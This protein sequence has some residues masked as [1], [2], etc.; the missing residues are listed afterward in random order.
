MRLLTLCLVFMF[1]VTGSV[2]SQL[3]TTLLSVLPG[4][5]DLS[6]W[7]ETQR[8][9]YLGDDLFYLI[10]GGAELYFEYGF[11]EVA[12]ILYKKGIDTSIQLIV[13]KMTDPWAALGIYSYYAKGGLAQD[14]GQRSGLFDNHL[15]IWKG[16]YF[17]TL[18]NLKHAQSADL[19]LIARILDTKIPQEE[20][21][22]SCL[23]PLL[24]LEPELGDMRI[25]RG[26]IALNA[27]YFFSASNIFSI[28]EGG[29]FETTGMKFIIACYPESVPVPDVMKEGVAILQ[30]S[31]KFNLV[32]EGP[33]GYVFTDKSGSSVNIQI[34]KKF[35]I[36]SVSESADNDPGDVIDLI[37]DM[38]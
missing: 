36:I 8:E 38:L 15:F 19:L 37:S 25:V 5:N 2:F 9:V 16:D 27:Y 26:N 34:I 12:S 18:A 35:L 21:M 31:N 7:Q 14:I 13:Y 1:S 11:K 20:N 32:E 29:V 17:I 10:N 33:S 6:D 22:E 30:D 24:E 28:S 4:E 23:T 3:D